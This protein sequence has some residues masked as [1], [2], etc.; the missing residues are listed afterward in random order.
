VLTKG[1]TFLIIFLSWHIFLLLPFLASKPSY[2]DAALAYL[3]LY[4]FFYTA[5]A[6]INAARD[7]GSGGSQ[8]RLEGPLAAVLP[9]APTMWMANVIREAEWWRSW[10]PWVEYLLI[11]SLPPFLLYLLRSALKVDRRRAADALA[12]LA[13]FHSIYA[14]AAMIST[15]VTGVDVYRILLW[16]FAVY[17]AAL[18]AA[19]AGGGRLAALTASAIYLAA[20][21]LGTEKLLLLLVA[22]PVARHLGL[23]KLLQNLRS[24]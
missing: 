15:A 2:S 1:Q 20:Y 13:V 4:P 24:A 22:I 8:E 18:A 10:N 23:Y 17:P 3:A 14:F 21:A 12:P 6:V 16:Y 11:A 5:Y 9:L 7:L 19:L